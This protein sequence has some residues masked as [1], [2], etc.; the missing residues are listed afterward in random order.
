[1]AQ[2]QKGRLVK[3]PY[4]PIHRDCAMD[5]SINVPEMLGTSEFVNPLCFSRMVRG[6]LRKEQRHW[7]GLVVNQD[8]WHGDMLN[9]ERDHF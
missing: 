3:G 4:D 8:T 6:H 7:P 1:M 2:T 9:I 5:F